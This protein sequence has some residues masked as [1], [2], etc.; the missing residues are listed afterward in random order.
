MGSFDFDGFDAIRREATEAISPV[1]YI[2]LNY[3]Y[4]IITDYKKSGLWR[5]WNKFYP[6]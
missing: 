6:C 1:I 5:E 4:T 3:I 2:F